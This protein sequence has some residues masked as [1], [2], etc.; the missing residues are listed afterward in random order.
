M[1]ER[2]TTRSIRI[3]LS[4]DK[5]VSEFQDK[6]TDESYTHAILRLVKL[7][8][9]SAN[10]KKE[11]DENPEKIKEITIKYEEMIARLLD[12]NVMCEVFDQ[13]PQNQI[14][15]LKNMIAIEEDSREQKRIKEK[16]LQIERDIE[17]R[18]NSFAF[19]V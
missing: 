8:L 1:S 9:Q 5:K 10:F 13:L 6:S 16:K 19:V 7:G 11:V 17:Y 12:E 3:K 15:A 2:T 14:N 4:L 18:K